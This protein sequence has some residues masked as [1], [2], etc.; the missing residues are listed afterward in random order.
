[1]I[2][3]LRPRRQSNR[4]R[5]DRVR[6]AGEEP[7][8]LVVTL[9]RDGRPGE[10]GHGELHVGERHERV[11]RSDLCSCSHRRL[12][13]FGSQGTRRVN[14][15][16]AAVQVEAP[17]QARQGIVG[18][19]EDDELDLIQEGGRLGEPSSSRHKG[20]KSLPTAR[21]AGGNRPDRPAGMGER[22]PESRA[23]RPGTHDPDDRRFIDS[24][25]EVRMG[26]VR[27]VDLV[28]MAVLARRNGIQVDPA[29]REFAECPIDLGFVL[30]P[31]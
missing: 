26:M 31:R 23:N 18:N 15:R 4:C 27:R 7:G 2:R 5:A 1:M 29:V 25:V 9:D 30:V 20:S 13:D 21:V 10:G 11:E 3:G 17:G 16:L 28:T 12:E 22:D 8:Q 24:R 19:G 14:H 6:H